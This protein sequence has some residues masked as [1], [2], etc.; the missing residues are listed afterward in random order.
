MATAIRYWFP[1]PGK[2]K[3][4]IGENKLKK[5]KGLI[6]YGF[7]KNKGNIQK[8]VKMHADRFG[9]IIVAAK[10]RKDAMKQVN[11]GIEMI[12]IIT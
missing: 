4:I 8:K 1:K 7:L 3:K 6:T 11:K 12:K 2:I 10:K 9:Y 5:L